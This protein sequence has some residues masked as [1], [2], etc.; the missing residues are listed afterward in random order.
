MRLFSLLHLAHSLLST[1][2]S[3]LFWFGTSYSV[4]EYSYIPFEVWL[5]IILFSALLT[6]LGCRGAAVLK[7]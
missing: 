5:I 3:P 7:N 6:L 2:Y 4:R 1:I